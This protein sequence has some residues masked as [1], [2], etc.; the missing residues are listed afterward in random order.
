MIVVC[1]RRRICECER[2][3][4]IHQ[5]SHLVSSSLPHVQPL[6]I[7]SIVRPPLCPHEIPKRAERMANIMESPLF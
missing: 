1:I 3:S 7:P 2:N 5:Q 6:H 4:E